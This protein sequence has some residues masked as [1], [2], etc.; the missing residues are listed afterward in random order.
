M[1]TTERRTQA[2]RRTTTRAALLEATIATLVEQGYGRTTTTEV[3]KR[4]GVSQGALFRHFP[5]KSALVAAA[6]EQLFAETIDEFSSAFE[7]TSDDD[8]S[9]G[10]ALRRLWHVFCSSKLQAVYRLYVEAPVDEELLAA[11]VPVVKRHEKNL[12]ERAH[13][14]FPELGATPTHGALFASMLFGMQGLS[15]QRPVYVNPEKE[16]LILEQFEVLA[17]SLIMNVQ[18]GDCRHA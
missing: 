16:K 17:R 11:L 13:Q 6:A 12:L 5:T 1:M 4:A 9:V 3:T 10:I 2:E 14:L 15:L 7:R 18:P 8:A